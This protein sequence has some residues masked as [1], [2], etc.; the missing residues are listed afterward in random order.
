[1]AKLQGFLSHIYFTLPDG[2]PQKLAHFSGYDLDIKAAEIDA[3]DH[4]T[5]GWSDKLDG[6]KDW[7]ATIDY[8][9]FDGDASQTAF[10]SA[11]LGSL[12]LIVEFRPKEGV[13]GANRTGTCR[14]TDWKE[15]AKG[16]TVQAR[17]V[18][19]SGRGPLTFG[20]ILAG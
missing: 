14:I 20:T 3:S 19:L 18:T 4:D 6:Y 7:S 10:E 12:D 1:M 13:G 11:L 8:I 5:D 9:T 16:S 2:P 17:N 15:S